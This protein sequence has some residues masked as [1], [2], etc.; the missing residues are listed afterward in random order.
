MDKIETLINLAHELFEGQS[1]LENLD[2]EDRAEAIR[3]IID[4]HGGGVDLV[5]VQ[6]YLDILDRLRRLDSGNKKGRAKL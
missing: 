3:A 1:I 5:K 4:I 6:Q 2:I